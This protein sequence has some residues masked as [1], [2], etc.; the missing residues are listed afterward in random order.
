[1][2]SIDL[3]NRE[4]LALMCNGDYVEAAGLLRSALRR[5]LNQVHEEADEDNEL[6]VALIEVS[7]Y[8]VASMMDTSKEYSIDHNTVS[9]F[10]RALS[11]DE[12]I[13]DEEIMSASVL[14]SQVSATLLYNMGLCYHLKGTMTAGNQESMFNKALKLYRMSTEVIKSA[15]VAIGTLV[16]L[17]VAN[18]MSHLFAH[19]F[20]SPELQRCLGWIRSTLS[21]MECDGTL[22][23]D[24]LHFRMNVLLLHGQEWKAAPA[25]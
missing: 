2:S 17:A 21:V 18:N 11:F 8:P 3:M 4:S 12:E 22:A 6:D 1:M 9:L 20:N 14:Q 10:D 5:I 25:A 19:S 24:Y 15:S 13:S 7:S 23:D 16:S